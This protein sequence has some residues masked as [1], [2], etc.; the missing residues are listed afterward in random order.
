MDGCNAADKLFVG[1]SIVVA[2]NQAFAPFG[3]KIL[4]APRGR[5]VAFNAAQ[6]K[7]LDAIDAAEAAARIER[8]ITDESGVFSVW[9]WTSV[10]TSAEV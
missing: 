8:R 2:G 4:S 6:A 9:V 3:A 7:I 10:V 5:A 1:E